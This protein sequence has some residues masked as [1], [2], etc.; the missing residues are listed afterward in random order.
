M[1]RA[2][3]WMIYGA[4]G[5]TGELIARKAVAMGL[6]PII[7]GRNAEKITRLSHELTLENRIFS[8]TGEQTVMERIEDCHLV[9][10]CAG[11]F[12]ETA[13]T[14]AKACI[15][16]STHYLDITGEIPVFES[17]Y[18]LGHEAEKAGVLLL[19]GV[20]FD[21]VPT[22]CLALQLKEKMLNATYLSLSFLSLGGIS[23][24][25]LKSALAQLP[26]GSKIRQNGQIVTIPHMSKT[27]S[28]RYGNK[29]L[30][31][32]SIPWGDV[33]TA[34]YTTGI[35]N[36]EVYTYFSETQAN[37]MSLLQP[38]SLLFKFEP[39]LKTAQ[40]LAG[41]SQTGP[42]EKV[43]ETAKSIIW[44]EVMDSQGKKISCRLETKEAYYLTVETSILAVKR[45]LEGK[46]LTGFKTPA[47]AFGKD[48]I[49]EVEGTKIYWE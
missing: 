20:G 46:I 12:I 45:V 24:G 10:H 19:P 49:L 26:Y 28:V 8:L 17:L 44:G 33:F 30:K 14:M 34:Y 25:T 43:R 36:I 37:I 6:K 7:A 21:V 40:W 3:Q 4:S 2:T 13:Q 41:I 1:K 29:E 48:F 35:P 27:H 15:A 47:L 18:R 22:D 31:M 9:L 5:Y 39:I 32:Y 11:P 16:T 23:P 42:S 38:I